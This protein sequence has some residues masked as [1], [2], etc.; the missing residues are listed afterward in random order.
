MKNYTRAIAF[1]IMAVLLAA[2]AYG[3]WV[4]VQDYQRNKDEVVSHV[5]EGRI[6]L[7]E[8]ESRELKMLLADNPE[9]K[10]ATTTVLSS[11]DPLIE[12]R[13]RV[14]VGTDFPYGHITDTSY[15]MNPEA[16]ALAIFFI[17]ILGLAA[18]GVACYIGIRRGF[19][20]MRE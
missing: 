8:D 17:T 16:L 12:F 15:K 14:P 13:A 7:Q 5:Y 4:I 3:S 6:Y 10:I 20:Q 19:F 2:T 1:T 11:A 9:I 18:S